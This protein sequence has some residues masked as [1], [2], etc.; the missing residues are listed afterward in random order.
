MFNRNGDFIR[1]LFPLIYNKFDGSPFVYFDNASTTQKPNC[2]IDSL[3]DFYRNKNSNIHRALYQLSLDASDDYENSRIN[4]QKFINAS[5]SYEIIFTKGTT[6]AINLVAS[7]FSK[8]CLKE[9][10][11]IIV[12]EMEHHSNF[13]PWQM[14]CEEKGAKLKVIPINDYGELCIEQF[15]NLISERTKL[16]AITHVSNSLGTINP[17]ESI[18]S[19]AHCEGIPVLVDGAQSIAHL[20]IDVQKLDCD[21]YAFSGHKMYGP[22]GIGVL[23]GKEKWLESLPPYQVGGGMINSVSLDRTYYSKIPFKFEAGTPPIAEVSGLSAAIDFL[24]DVGW[25]YLVEH[26]L[27]LLEYAT[28]KLNEISDIQI[29]GPSKNKI[30]I[31]SFIAN[32]GHSSDIGILLNQMGIAIRTGFHCN[33]PL[34]SKMKLNGTS[35]ISFG[36]YNT[37]NEI[38]FLLEK[39]VKA[40]NMIK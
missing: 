12:S 32:S 39:L 35:R 25:D 30:G 16:V 6:E 28:L 24:N 3:I 20:K 26:E 4:V 36:L 15:Q 27:N 11:E 8:M 29:I 23:Y 34:M 1:S 18:I 19:I 33:Q 2:V 14:V 31:I 17:M 22:T 7:S 40:L 13:V 21:F 5:N 9:G 10:D 37:K 38:D